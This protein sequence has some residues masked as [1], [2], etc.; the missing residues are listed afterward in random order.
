MKRV[1]II[2]QKPT[3]TAKF[4]VGVAVNREQIGEL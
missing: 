4:S 3:Q 2:K 1:D